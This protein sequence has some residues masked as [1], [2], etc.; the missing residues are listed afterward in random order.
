MTTILTLSRPARLGGAFLLLATLAS[1]QSLI[2]EIQAEHDPTK[3]SEKALTVADTAF[4]NA[5]EDYNK[6]EIHKGDADLEIMMTALEE[7][8]SSLDTAHKA[9]NYKKAEMNV[10]LLQRRL[11]GLLDDIALQER[12]W[13]EYTN[14]KLDELHDKLLDGVMRK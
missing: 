1:A 2:S 9:K 8:V 11:K 6:G 10:A 12:G 3:R 14:R 7:C 5:R 13:A 4:D